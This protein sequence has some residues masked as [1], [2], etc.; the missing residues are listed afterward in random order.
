MAGQLTSSNISLMFQV[1]HDS[2]CRIP[3]GRAH[4]P[5]TYQNRTFYWLKKNSHLQDII[6]WPIKKHTWMTPTAAQ[7]Q[8]FNW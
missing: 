6:P 7:I 3:A 8:P 4:Y 2:Q 1:S 5:T